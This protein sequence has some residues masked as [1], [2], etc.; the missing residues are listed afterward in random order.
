LDC[1]FLLL[2][3]ALP[4]SFKTPGTNSGTGFTQTEWEIEQLLKKRGIQEL[5]I[6]SILPRLRRIVSC[7]NMWEVVQQNPLIL[8]WAP[9][10][11]I[12]EIEKAA[13]P[14]KKRPKWK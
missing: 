14:A 13:I 6:T 2:G 1:W 7:K 9:A 3:I 12:T 10:I 4:G 5:T 8:A 11:I